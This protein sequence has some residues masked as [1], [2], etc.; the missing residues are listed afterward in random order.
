MTDM[1]YSYG[2]PHS[3]DRKYSSPRMIVSIERNERVFKSE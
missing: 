3:Y 2:K 1:A